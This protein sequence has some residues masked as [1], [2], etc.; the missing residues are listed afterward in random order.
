MAVVYITEYANIAVGPGGRL[1]QIPEEPPLAEQTVVIG[2]G[3][4]QSSAFN[5]KT[6]VIR[7]ASDAI[8]AVLVG[9]NPTAVNGTSGRMAAGQTEYR[10]IPATGGPYKIAVITTS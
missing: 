8:C 2:A 5:S 4:L 3:S 7:V 9:T 10:G 6:R 1:S